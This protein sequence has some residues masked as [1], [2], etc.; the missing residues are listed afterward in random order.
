M[1]EENHPCQEIELLSANSL[2]TEPLKEC[3]DVDIVSFPSKKKEWTGLFN[4]RT[5]EGLVVNQTQG[6]A[7]ITAR[8]L[9]TDPYSPEIWL[10]A[11]KPVGGKPEYSVEIMSRKTLNANLVSFKKN[12]EYTAEIKHGWIFQVRNCDNRSRFRF[13]KQVCIL[14]LWILILHSFMLQIKLP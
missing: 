14:A 5:V 2:S 13:H 1:P 6:V 10:P 11:V 8:I 7:F 3:V 12:F 9:R 4:S